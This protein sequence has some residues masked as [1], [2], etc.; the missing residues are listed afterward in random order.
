MG[1][2]YNAVKLSIRNFTV[3]L[4]GLIFFFFAAHLFFSW[5]S[6]AF[7]H[8]YIFG[9]VP[10]FRLNSEQSF[11]TWYSTLALA[12]SAIL[13]FAIYREKFVRLD[14]FSRH[15][16]GLACIFAFL[17]ADEACSIHEKISIFM[18]S[19]VS[20]FGLVSGQWTAV[21]AVPVIILAFVYLPFLRHLWPRPAQM[22]VVAGAVF[23]T[24]AV[25]L[26]LVGAYYYTAAQLDTSDFL[27]LVIAG[28]EDLF[29]MLGILLWMHSLL[30]YMSLNNI[31]LQVNPER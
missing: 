20:A 26:E 21:Y 28:T 2:I 18:K 4:I 23:V 16:L 13:L 10:L 29:E 12:L 7:G 24:G 17:S 31:A 1:G 11:S 3:F 14:R 25:G 19:H 5:S 30:V 15:W 9:L 22:F 27:Y 6:L 8:D